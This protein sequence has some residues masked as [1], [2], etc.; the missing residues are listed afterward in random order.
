MTPAFSHLSSFPRRDLLAIF[1]VALAL[2]TLAAAFISRPGYMDAYYYFGG[3][4]QLARGKG[5]TE[6]YLWNY[7][8]IGRTA[9]PSLQVF[10]TWETGVRGFPGHLY[11][12]PLTSIIAAPFIVI[13]G[14]NRPATELF[15]AA[16]IPSVLL[17]SALPLLSYLVATFT[18]GLRRHAL[19]AA[20]LTVFSGFY[21]LYWADTDSF[22][23]YGC[24]GASALFF[25]AL[26]FRAS[27]PPPVTSA[28]VR[29]PKAVRVYFFCAGLCAGL[30]HLTRA[31]GVFLLFLALAFVLY[32]VFKCGIRNTQSVQ[33]LLTHYFLPLLL[34]YLIPA[35]PWFLRNF[36][37]VGSPLVP[38][39]SR[40]LW[41]TEY[42]DLFNYPAD[43]L[44]LGRY[45][46]QGWGAMLAG[47]WWALQTNLTRLVA[48]QGIIV[49]APF[50]LVGLWKLRREA[51]YA[52]ALIY[53]GMVF[54]LMTFVFP[55]PGARG[56]LFHSGAALLPFLYPAAIVGLDAS[57]VAGTRFQRWMITS[58]SARYP[59]LGLLFPPWQ[60]AKST[61]IFTLL[62]VLFAAVLTALIF[63]SGVVGA[64]WRNPKSAQ[65]DE[66]YVEVG[67][68]L[69][70]AGDAQSAIA[71]NDPPGFYFFTA[72][73]SIMI[74]N[75]NTDTLVRAMRDFGAQWIVLDRNYPAGLESLYTT[76]TVAAP[77]ILRATFTDDQ[78]KP[79]YLFELP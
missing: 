23:L 48:E 34:G 51:L 60:P 70:Q 25:I 50:I 65:V 69:A 43:T 16:Q 3:A 46:A 11:W 30:A 36:I 64:D 40:A 13:A 5:F 26:A 66:V 61:P 77:L 47:K 52:P 17:A 54:A 39:T 32:V 79:V 44:T 75:G 33:S 7:L 37:T 49:A 45:L 20:A 73:P 38:G 76:P 9:S 12:M 22:A 62:L 4:L 71:V 78:Q 8:S 19:A 42:N 58:L 57:V 55:F 31:D 28:P 21:T 67:Q 15:R 10:S 63:R 56:G 41:L 14:A 2:N 35:A 1:L 74:P 18:T 59:A 29:L 53:F 72:H 68:W 27:S 24:I 6:P